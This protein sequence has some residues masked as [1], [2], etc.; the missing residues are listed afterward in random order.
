ME[1]LTDKLFTVKYN[2]DC[3]TPRGGFGAQF[4]FG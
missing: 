2:I 1:K 4:K 3:H